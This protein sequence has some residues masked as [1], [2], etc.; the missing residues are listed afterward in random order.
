M[1]SGVLTVQL[2]LV[3]TLLKG[4]VITSFK[5]DRELGV[6]SKPGNGGFP[7]QARIWRVRDEKT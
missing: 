3:L 1:S 4:R 2:G 7:V 6:L 5:P